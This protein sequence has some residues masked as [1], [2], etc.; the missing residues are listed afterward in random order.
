M[1][2]GE[3]VG[4][5]IQRIG[6]G[7]QIAEY[8]VPG[9]HGG[10]QILPVGDK[11]ADEGADQECHHDAP[12]IPAEALAV[13]DDEVDAQYAQ[14]HAPAGVERGEALQKRD[15]I[16]DG[17]L[18]GPVVVGDEVLDGKEQCQIDRQEQSP[19]HVRVVV[20]K[21]LNALHRYLR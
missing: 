6:V 8:V 21:C 17:Q 13:L 4:V 2:A 3:H 16:V 9:H 7:H 5:G 1:D 15:L 12:H 18:R 19:P 14:Q 20:D 10:P 11:G